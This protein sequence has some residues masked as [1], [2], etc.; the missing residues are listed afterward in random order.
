MKN[1][2]EGQCECGAATF[3]KYS[4]ET[5]WLWHEPGR[6]A[7]GGTNGNILYCPSCGCYLDGEG[8]AHPT[9]VVPEEPEEGE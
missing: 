4:D 1:R 8:F 3:R 5:Y 7:L 9:V 6:G 2:I